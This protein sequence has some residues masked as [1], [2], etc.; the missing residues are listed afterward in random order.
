MLYLMSFP[1]SM[2]TH[3]IPALNIQ[4]NDKVQIETKNN[5]LQYTLIYHSKKILILFH[6]VVIIYSHT[7]FAIKKLNKILLT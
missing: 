3:T 1:S 6:Y 7:I 4:D 2:K 5:K